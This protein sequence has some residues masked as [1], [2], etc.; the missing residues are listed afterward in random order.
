MDWS[1]DGRFVLYR[2]LNSETAFDLWAIPLDG[3]RQPFPIVQ[4]EFDEREGQFSPDGKWIAYASN[5]S[6]RVEVYLRPFPGPGGDLRVSAA[7]GAQ[8]RW[9]R[10]G[11]E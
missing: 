11:N 10:D 1:S 8:R 5:Q 4:T 9:R 6:G 3:D 2:H 7:G